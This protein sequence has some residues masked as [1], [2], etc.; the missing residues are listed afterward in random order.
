MNA[1]EIMNFEGNTNKRAKHEFLFYQMCVPL[2]TKDKC[3]F[4]LD[5]QRTHRLKMCIRVFRN[6]KPEEKHMIQKLGFF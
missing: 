4:C 5:K 2:R 1:Y 6:P 3:K